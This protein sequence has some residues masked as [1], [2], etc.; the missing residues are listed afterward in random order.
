MQRVANVMFALGVTFNLTFGPNLGWRQLANFNCF[1]P[2][3]FTPTL[4]TARESPVWLIDKGRGLDAIHAMKPLRNA[5]YDVA[6][7]LFLSYK[8][9]LLQVSAELLAEMSFVIALDPLNILRTS[10][11]VRSQSLK[12]QKALILQ[13]QKLILCSTKLEQDT[14]SIFTGL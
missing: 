3:L 2:I 7:E 8:Q 13:R 5:R 4:F 9:K 6:K 11:R 12:S 10:S 14:G 1:L